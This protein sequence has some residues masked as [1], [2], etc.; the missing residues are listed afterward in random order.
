M[1]GRGVSDDTLPNGD[2]LP[3]WGVHLR[4]FLERLLS[5][6][7]EAH[8][9]KHLDD[10]R[11]LDQARGAIDL[12]L[13]KLNELRAEVLQ[14]RGQFVRSDVYKKDVEVL[15]NAIRELDRKAAS[16]EAV[17]AY[18]RLVYGAVIVGVVSLAIALFNLA[19]R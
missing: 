10:E 18:K 5:E 12:R 6:Y 7:R 2:R 11:A 4:E 8:R 13:E 19:T 14:D 17:E 16:A 1:G 15:N 3:P 9:Q